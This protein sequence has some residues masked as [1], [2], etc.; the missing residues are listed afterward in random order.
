[1]SF[2]NGTI[3]T[4]VRLFGER[5]NVLYASVGLRMLNAACIGITAAVLV[6]IIRQLADGTLG[7]DDVWPSTLVIVAAV[8]GQFVTGYLANYFAWVSTFE[9]IGEARIRTLAHLNRLPIGAVLDRRSGDVSA[10]L[11]SD[12]EMVSNFAHHGMQ[13]V[14][15]AVAL[16]VVVMIIL[17]FT[18]PTLAAA[19]AVSI[20]VA[21]PVF[22]LANR[23][24][25]ALSTR[26]ADQLAVGNTRMIEY[27]QGVGVARSFNRTGA[28]LRWFRDAVAEVR[29]VNDAMAVKLVPLAIGAIGI[30]QLGIPIVIAFGA[31]RLFD[32]STDVA[33]VLA[34]LVLVARVYTPLIQ[35][36]MQVEAMRLADASLVRIGR[37]MDIAEQPVPATP[38]TEPGAAAVQFDGVTFGYGERTV[39]HDVSFTVPAGT[40]TA[41]VG[42]SGAGKSTVLNLIARAWDTDRGSVHVG[43]VDVRELTADQ[44]FDLVTVVFQDVYLFQGTIRENIAF[45][46]ESATDD[47]VRRA[48]RLAQAEAFVDA[49][50]DGYDTPVGEGGQALSGGE[51]QRVS[52]ARAMLKQSPIVLL[53]EATASIDPLNERAVQAGL[54]ELVRDRTLV[55]VAHRLS[56]IRS[57][58]QILVMHDGRIVERGDHESLLA[59]GGRYAE[60]WRERERAARWRVGAGARA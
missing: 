32:G 15:G 11:T 47:D 16:P 30:V 48:A 21:V 4:T 24:F 8:T 1:M 29:A 14:F 41:I 35:V 58:D 7:S 19:T 2:Y 31:L 40:M 46:D 38:I 12:F 55:V 57:A 36:A 52:I 51:R 18:D 56:T 3:R 59:A 60:L 53:D 54:A 6:G 25:K 33:V 44:L 17:A 34:F 50:P 42:S 20:V 5:R 10:V 39:L 43:G 37:I 49:F 22:L 26:R 45:G 9:A 23:R 13:H 28:R 27:V